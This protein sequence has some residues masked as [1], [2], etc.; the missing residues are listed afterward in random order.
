ML[1][2]SRFSQRLLACFAAG[3]LFVTATGNDLQA[4]GYCGCEPSCDVCPPP[5]VDGCTCNCGHAKK[6]NCLKK[7]LDGIAASFDKLMSMGKGGCDDMLCDDAC[8]AAMIEELMVPMPMEMSE[9]H[10]H[11][12]HHHHG[13]EHDNA[14]PMHDAHS[15]DQEYEG[16]M[17]PP[18]R[19]KEP[20]SNPDE[21]S[22]F[23]TQSDPFLDDDEARIRAYR[24][25]RP[26]A[27]QHG[28]AYQNRGANPSVELR[29]APRP[30]ISKR[31]SSRRTRSS[32]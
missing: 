19:M 2:Q 6:P 23:D 24:P 16:E 31:Y 11:N 30:E 20:P 12:G 21:G 17:P 15:G 29:P 26:S 7:A 3:C 5:I 22:L 13:H 25:I 4:A 8:D 27:Y 28:N 1:T 18:V 9:V 32:R 10:H 14:T